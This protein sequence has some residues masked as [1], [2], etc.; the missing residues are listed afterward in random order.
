MA[1]IL[2]RSL[3][4][5]PGLAL[6]HSAHIL[7]EVKFRGS[8]R[9]RSFGAALLSTLVWTAAG[10]S[11]RPPNPALAQQNT[12]A[13][14]AR[15]NAGSL[16]EPIRRGLSSNPDTSPPEIEELPQVPPPPNSTTSPPGAYSSPDLLRLETRYPRA[17]PRERLRADDPSLEVP[18]SIATRI[19]ALDTNLSIL[20]TRGGNG[21]VD[22][23][24]SILSGALSITLGVFVE[25]DLLGPY[26]YLWG[27]ANVA[28]G[29]VDI[30]L[31]PNV[32]E[33]SIKFAHM[34]METAADIRS[35]LLFGESSLREIA[36]AN[37]IARI[38]DAS[39]NVGV[40][41]A[42]IPMYLIPNDFEVDT[43]FDYFVLIGSGISVISGAINLVR[44]SEAERRWAAYQ[45]LRARLQQ[46]SAAGRRGATDLGLIPNRKGALVTLQ[47][48][49]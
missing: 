11:V 37:R 6:Y 40:G 45:D 48:R 32:S 19:R 44:R 33:A 36:K 30:V 27:S 8:T 2:A 7:R 25:D 47:R 41:L 12:T 9:R 15:E 34:P 22:G 23:V 31:T 10:A 35:R 18:A 49:F 43:P 17:R 28:R 21:V 38:L 20:A 5:S 1:A 13:N 16:G 26:L 24:L 4:S 14:T 46:R 39:L 42:V 29:V 3:G